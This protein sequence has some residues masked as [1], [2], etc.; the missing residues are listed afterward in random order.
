MGEKIRLK[1]LEDDSDAIAKIFNSS[2]C[3]LSDYLNI[4][5]KVDI[6]DWHYWS[7]VIGFVIVSI[8]VWTAP[9]EYL[10]WR[11]ILL[12][13]QIATM[14]LCIC[15]THM[16]FKAKIIT[17]IA[18]FFGAI[19]ILITLDVFTPQEAGIQIYRHGTELI[20]KHLP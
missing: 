17:A 1:D 11:K 2:G 3:S 14:A 10:V 7:A 18:T 19:I 16:R 12:V 5:K 6:K 15:L 8:L 9:L 13:V 4:S 20:D